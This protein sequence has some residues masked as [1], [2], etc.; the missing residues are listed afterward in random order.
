MAMIE[1]T[2]E[3]IVR[4]LEERCWQCGGRGKHPQGK[5]PD[6][7]AGHENEALA[8]MYP[9]DCGIC[10]G[11][12]YR[13]TAAGDAMVKWLKRWAEVV[14]LMEPLSE[15]EIGHLRSI[16][17]CPH[18]VEDC[19]R[20]EPCGEPVIDNIGAAW[21][22]THFDSIIATIDTQAKQIAELNVEAQEYFNRRNEIQLKYV[23]AADALEDAQKEIEEL[24]SRP[25]LD[26]Q[27]VARGK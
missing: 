16:R 12:G 22:D 10:K 18:D 13:L 6:R 14:K 20:L 1:V 26:V 27:K 25:P 11:R 7:W 4:E 19:P 5:R 8:M 9:D 2:A 15:E 21:I 23:R 3:S 24:Q 17:V